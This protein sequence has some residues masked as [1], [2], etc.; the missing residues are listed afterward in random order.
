MYIAGQSG[1]RG[2]EHGRQG[3][4]VMAKARDGRVQRPNILARNRE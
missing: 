3:L 4:E 2:Q 1:G